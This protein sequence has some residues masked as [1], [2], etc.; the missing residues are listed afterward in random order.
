MWAQIGDPFRGH[1]GSVCYVPQERAWV[2]VHFPSCK[3]G[4][5]FREEMVVTGL[6]SESCQPNELALNFHV[7][8]YD[9]HRKAKDA[10]IEA[11]RRKNAGEG[12][13]R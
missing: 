4:V 1:G 8:C 10:M 6:C 3:D 7:S 12:W 13:G 9:A 11:L 5:D 2:A